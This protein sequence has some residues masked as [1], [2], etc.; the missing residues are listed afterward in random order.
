MRR[1]ALVLLV[2]ACRHAAP[3]PDESH[4]TAPVI[5]TVTLTGEG[6]PAAIAYRDGDASWTEVAASAGA[7][8][9]TF[10]VSSRRYEVA[11]GCGKQARRRAHVFAF[12][13]DSRSTIE[14]GLCPPE[15]T[16]V[17]VN[18]TVAGLESGASAFAFT[19]FVGARVK[20]GTFHDRAIAG[21]ADVVVLEGDGD[22]WERDASWATRRVALVRTTAA[23]GQEI[24]VDMT[25]DGGEADHRTVTIGD[26]APYE[27]PVVRSE[28]ASAHRAFATLTVDRAAP[29]VVDLV[30]QHMLAEGDAVT[31][32]AEA[33]AE[34][35]RRWTYGTAVELPF[36]SPLGEVIATE[37][38]CGLRLSWSRHEQAASYRLYAK[39]GKVSYSATIDADWFEPGDDLELVTPRF[40]MPGWEVFAF[41]PGE[42]ASWRLSASDRPPLA[43]PDPART[44]RYAERD[45]HV[46]L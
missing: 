9:Y 44:V 36:L 2:A 3:A 32:S 6:D 24:A 38:A 13:R 27:T 40:G 4:A 45:G 39:A 14:V 25:R 41:P 1:C 5:V 23:E 37:A 30:P 16:F 15:L 18:G 22:L 31:F 29:Y 43:D 20:A 35:Q 10:S 19:N 8:T 46:T 21:A 12:A 34:G 28:L 33:V 17:N 42:E 11:I 7:G 26:V